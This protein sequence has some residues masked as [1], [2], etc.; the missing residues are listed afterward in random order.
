MTQVARQG[1]SYQEK[2][3]RQHT[4]WQH[5]LK[6]WCVDDQ[7]YCLRD[8]RIFRTGTASVAVERYFYKLP[9][10]NPGDISLIRGLVIDGAHPAAK[11]TNES[12]LEMLTAPMQFE[13]ET[14]VLDDIVDTFRTNALEDWHADIEAS[15]LP[16]LSS[17]INED[18]GFYSSDEGCMVFLH[19]ACA[20]YMRTKGIKVRT[21]ERLKQ[22]TGRDVSRIW[23]ILSYMLSGS[24]GASLFVERKRR[25]LVLMHNRT[26]VTF[27]TGDQPIINLHATRPHPPTALA[28]YYPVSPRLALV[29]SEVDETP[30]F[31]AD[32][33]TTMEVLA[34]NAKMFEESHSQ[35]FGQSEASLGPS[36]D[37]LKMV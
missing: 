35:I 22:T 8:G 9:K 31:S 27:I 34:L 19:F 25:K 30:A 15:F 20:Q 24:I 29:L 32:N 17:T 4:V 5:Y 12:F 10:L 7:L 28:L 18:I 26:D 16:L 13:G 23:D 37:R 3:R 21:I 11:E 6:S 14:A 33:P 1:R 2:K 36:R